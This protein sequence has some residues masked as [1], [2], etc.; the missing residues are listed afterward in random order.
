MSSESV[1]KI[2][3]SDLGEF[4][5]LFRPFSGHSRK[6]CRPL[7]VGLSSY[8]GSKCDFQIKHYSQLL[9]IRMQRVKK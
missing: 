9:H 3:N 7:K 1:I 8:F 6:Y 4:Q 5:S 2:H